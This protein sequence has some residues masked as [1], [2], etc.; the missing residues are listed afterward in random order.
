M[1]EEELQQLRPGT[2]IKIRTKSIQY[3]VVVENIHPGYYPLLHGI[4]ELYPSSYILHWSSMQR[5]A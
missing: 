1:T 5:V 4:K 2:L 3:L